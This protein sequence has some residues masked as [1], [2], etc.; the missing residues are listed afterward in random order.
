VQ[1]VALIIITARTNWDNE[2]MKAI[3]RLR[4]TAVDDG[5][6]PIVDDIE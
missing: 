5:T 6:V 1:T 3:Q 2:V 4:Q